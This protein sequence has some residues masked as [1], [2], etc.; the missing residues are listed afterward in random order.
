MAHLWPTDKFKNLHV[1]IVFRLPLD[2]RA[3]ERAMLP[4]VLRRGTADLPSSRL[5]AARLE[6]LYG[7]SLRAD[8]LKFGEQQWLVFD[9]EVASARY[10]PSGHDV[11]PE[12]LDLLGSLWLRPALV[13]GV[14]RSDWVEQEK[15]NLGHLIDSVI[16]DKG[17]YSVMRM[18]QSMCHGE[19]YA[20]ARYG[21]KDDI[22]V[23][24]A[25]ALTRQMEAV[26]AGAPLE[27]YVAGDIDV[28]ACGQ[29]LER[30]FAGFGGDRQALEARV[31]SRVA[32]PEPRRINE[33]QKVNQGKLAMGYRTDIT[34][35]D[36]SYA[37][38]VVMNGIFGAYSHSKLFQNVREK[39]SLAY[40]AMS[41]LDGIKGLMLVQS[42]IDPR[43]LDAALGIIREQHEDMMEGRFDEPEVEN[44]LRTLENQ[45]HSA[46]D[47]P[48]HLM[49][50]DLEMRLTGRRQDLAATIA[51]LRAV[52]RD[53]IVE[54]ARGVRLD[55][56]FF[57]DGEAMA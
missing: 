14:L 30:A 11:L 56:V 12:A 2:E 43:N 41:R 42:G 27:I 16:N 19:P 45:L 49:M 40:Y 47:N 17:Q 55:T 21:R 15:A 54:A 34:A 33:R 10:L 18:I 22:A 13:D 37:D 51:R 4:M 52:T 39:A 53:G 28:D 38:L 8:T 48:T 6:E 46:L 1:R 5:L 36:P 20:I 29:Q 32:P 25:A 57:L 9:L 23:I 35:F 31:Q 26:L 50:S 7:A 44:T 3:T 24:D